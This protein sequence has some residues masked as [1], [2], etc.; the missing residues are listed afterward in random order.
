MLIFFFGFGICSLSAGT[1]DFQKRV[2]NKVVSLL[3]TSPLIGA[4]VTGTINWMLW[5]CGST[6]TK[7]ETGRKIMILK[8][9]FWANFAKDCYF[10][11]MSKKF[12]KKIKLNYNVC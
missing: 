6:D 3:S 7:P 4:A 11:K 2:D 8:G 5:V 1:N 12:D 9:R 10:L